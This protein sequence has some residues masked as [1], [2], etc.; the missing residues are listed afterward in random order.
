MSSPR[1]AR[2]TQFQIESIKVDGHEVSGITFAIEIYEN[3]FSFAITGSILLVETETNSFLKD[4]RIEGNEPLEL[5]VLCAAD[6]RL[7][8]KGYVNRIANLTIAPS[9]EMTY[10]L[11]FVS[12]FIRQNEQTYITKR[13][14]NTAP[15][16]VMK[17]ALKVLNQDAE[18]PLVEDQFKGSGLPMNFIASN[19]SPKRLINY[20]QRKGV[21]TRLM[22]DSS[23]RSGSKDNLN[24]NETASGTGG[25]LFYETLKGFRCGSAIEIL[26]GEIGNQDEK[27][28]R[29]TLANQ[30]ESMEVTR[31]HILSYNNVQNNDT[32]TQQLAGA[33]H[34]ELVGFNLDTG[35][36]VRQTWKSELATDKQEQT[37]KKPTRVFLSLIQNETFTNDCSKTSDN[38]N[39]QTLINLQQS[40][41]TLNNLS[42][43]VCQLTLPIRPDINVGDLIKLDIYKVSLKSSQERDEKS[44]GKWIVSGLAHHVMI[45]NSAA[46]SRVTCIRSTNQVDEATASQDQPMHTRLNS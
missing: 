26:D 5:E 42:D 39:D 23:H 1:F 29:Y 40:E 3:I 21:P 22:G 35:D 20:V 2:N 18:I 36:Y 46:Y 38:V 45:E 9:G 43:N 28:F 8:F 44:S 37:S 32:Q 31:N 34:S 6:E 19:W 30:G 16:E 24:T 7:K 25:F 27:E 41:G 33:F 17:D 11:E 10:S 12:E 4:K 13:Y 15:V 14:D